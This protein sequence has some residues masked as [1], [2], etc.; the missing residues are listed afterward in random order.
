MR[1]RDKRRR[2]RGQRERND[3]ATLPVR[4]Q[5]L[6]SPPR[7]QAFTPVEDAR[8]RS[9]E[10]FPERSDGGAE[11]KDKSLRMPITIRRTRD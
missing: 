11:Y 7:V 10:D 6:T 3:A 4:V 2:V 8:G 1:K 9:P 5:A